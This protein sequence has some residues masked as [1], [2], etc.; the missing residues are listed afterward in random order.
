MKFYFK[1]KI[2][3]YSYLFIL[4]L[5]VVPQDTV[6]FNNTI[7]YNIQYGNIDAPEAEIILAAKYADIHERI[8]TFPE[9][10]ETM[11]TIFLFPLFFTITVQ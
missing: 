2:K 10:Y 11:V 6:L 9:G 8:L 1:E 7:K 5:G 3:K 4:T